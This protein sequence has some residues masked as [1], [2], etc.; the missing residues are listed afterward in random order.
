MTI[1]NKFRDTTRKFRLIS[2]GDKILIGVSGGPD[3]VALLYLLCSLKKELRLKLH[4]AHLDH[5]LRKDSHKDREFVESLGVSLKIPVTASQVNVKDLAKSGSVEEIARNARLGFLFR[6]AGEIKA[7]KIA[8]GHNFDDQAET[9]MMRILRGTGLYGLTG[10]SPKREIAGYKVIRPL[11][12]TR[13]IDIEAYL[14]NR[15]IPSRTDLSNLEEIYFRN[16]IRNRLFPLLEK[17]YNENIKSVLNN[18]AESVGYDYDYLS[19]VAN[20]ALKGMGTRIDLDKFLRLRPAIQRLVLRFAIA[21][22]KGDTRRITFQHIRE[23]EDLILN[24]PVNS[25]VDLPKGISV[26][27]K[28]K[29]LVFSLRK[30]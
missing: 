13:R 29:F 25:V 16:S 27:K 6:V 12:E 1:L 26:A 4:I 19:R 23:L 7:D 28:K 2:K 21:R 3:S 10:I 18:M 20:R 8:L 22:V 24:R 15:K 30:N 11:I 5:M 9:I 17:E 14:R